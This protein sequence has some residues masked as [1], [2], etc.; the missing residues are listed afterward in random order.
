MSLTYFFFLNF[1]FNNYIK[2]KMDCVV[3]NVVEPKFENISNKLNI[4]QNQIKELQISI[5]SIKKEQNSNKLLMQNLCNL[6]ENNT[7]NICNI[8]NI[9]NIS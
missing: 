8:S 5:D 7:N 4:I 3:L 2:Y 6:L 9:S 1:Y